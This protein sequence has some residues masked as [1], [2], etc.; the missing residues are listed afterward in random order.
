MTKKGLE[1]CSDCNDYPCNRFDSARNGYDSFVTH[2][3]VFTNLDFIKGNGIDCFIDQQKIRINILLDFLA[4]YD[5]GRSK[6]FFC[7]SCSLLPL[8]E[9]QEACRFM[10]N[11]DDSIDVKDKNERLVDCLQEIAENL[12]IEL[13]LNN[14]K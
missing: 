10:K 13:K 11:L 5:N 6:S 3:K 8:D 9:L 1:V 7:I 4:N 14:K 12:E 2:R